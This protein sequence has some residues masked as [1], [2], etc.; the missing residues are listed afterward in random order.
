M[1]Y[2]DD[3]K[4]EAL[5]VLA[6]CKND[7]AHAV[8]FLSEHHQIEVSNKQLRRWAKGEFTNEVVDKNVPL[9]KASLADRLEALAHRFVDIAHEKAEDAPVSALMTGV[10][11]AVDKMRLLRDEST[12]I[13]ESRSEASHSERVETVLTLLTGGDDCES[14]PG[15]SEDAQEADAA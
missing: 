3:Q 6:A 2:T 7:Y 1:A 10:G 9:K 12:T 14:V 4:A 15:V 13:N 5:T 11:I 8:R